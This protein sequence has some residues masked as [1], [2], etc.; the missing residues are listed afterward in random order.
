MHCC[1]LLWFP[2]EERQMD[3]NVG[4]SKAKHFQSNTHISGCFLYQLFLPSSSSFCLV[5]DKILDPLQ[6]EKIV[7]PYGGILL[8]S[9]CDKIWQHSVLNLLRNPGESLTDG[10][11]AWRKTRWKQALRPL[12]T[13][14]AARASSGH[15]AAQHSKNRVLQAT[16]QVCKAKGTVQVQNTTVLCL[17]SRSYSHVNW[18]ESCIWDCAFLP[19]FLQSKERWSKTK[20]MALTVP[21]SACTD[22][23]YP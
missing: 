12:T 17:A 19:H 20:A 10:P 6:Q 5:H 13:G 14:T 8:I 23:K 22:W 2:W 1:L 15:W 4:A 11:P 9:E 16:T 7:F 18:C 3:N 21:S